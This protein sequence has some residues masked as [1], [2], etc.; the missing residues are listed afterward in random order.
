MAERGPPASKLPPACKPMKTKATDQAKITDPPQPAPQPQ[1]EPEAQVNPDQVPD[2]APP[3]PQ[4]PPVP[5]PPAYIPEPVQPQ[6]PPAHI[7]DPIQPLNPPAHIPNS[8]LPPAPPVQIP[9]LNWSY[10]KPEFSGKPE[11]DAEAHLLRTNDWMETHNFPGVAKVHRF[12]LT[13]TS[14]TRLWYETL[15]PIVG[16]WTG[17]Q[18]CFRQQYSK[19]GNT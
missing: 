3:N 17:L 12:C 7:P 4:D 5:A 2:L 14:E 10:F 19:F 8:M 15:G 16:D 9:Q 11:E 6:N 1:P 18:E 13:L